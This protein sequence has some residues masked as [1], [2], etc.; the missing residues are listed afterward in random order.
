MSSGAEED[1]TTYVAPTVA[2]ATTTTTKPPITVVLGPESFAATN[3]LM[4]S[5]IAV[6]GLSGGFVWV[7]RS[8]QVVHEQQVGSVSGSTV[9]SV[10]SSTKWL[11]AATLMSLVDDGLVGLDDPVAKWLPEFSATGPAITVRQ[12]LTHTSGVRDN[13]CQGNGTA[14]ASCVRSIAGSA[15][16]FSP[17]AKFSY[18]N[19]DFLVIGRVVEVAGGADFATVVQQ[20]LTGPLAMT[21]TTWPGAPMATNPAF[22]VRVSIDD[23]GR[24]LDMV[25]HRGVFE[26]QRI[27]SEAAVAELIGNQVRD[28]DVTGDFAVGITKIP[29]YALGAWPDV[30]DAFGGTVV[31]SGNG[32]MG[33]YPWVDYATDSYGII[34]VQDER[35]ARLAVPASQAVAISARSVLSGQN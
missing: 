29:R 27:L 25:L 9:L 18:G 24:F 31:V 11:T 32:G 12:L 28:Y 2:I 1:P 6:A 5:R 19:S 20:R 17:G 15:R 33:F 14:L 22:G 16:E 13:A 35:G 10:A 7:V 3:A 4:T 34:G 26:G 8:G 23:Y 21:A 30:V